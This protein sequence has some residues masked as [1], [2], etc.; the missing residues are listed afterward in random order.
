MLKV[1]AQYILL[2]GGSLPRVLRNYLQHYFTM[3]SQETNITDEGSI[4]FNISSTINGPALAVALG[5]EMILGIITNL[6]IIIASFCYAKTLKNSSTILLLFLAVAN[7]FCCV[8][9]M[10][11]QIITAAVQEWIFGNTVE[12]REGMCVFVGYILSFS[13]II[14]YY[15]LGAISFDRFLMIVKPITHRTIMTP[16]VVL[17][18]CTTIVAIVALYAA[19]PLFGVGAIIFLPVVFTCSAGWATRNTAFFFSSLFIATIPVIIII[20]TSVWTFMF[21]RTFIKSDHQRR[22]QSIRTTNRQEYQKNIYN[23]RI[24]KLFGIFG[25]LLISN[26]ISILPFIAIGI[27]G[28]LVGFRTIPDPIYGIVMFVF[29]LN[30]IANA[31]AQCYFRPELKKTLLTFVKKIKTLYKCDKIVCKCQK[32]KKKYSPDDPSNSRSD[33]VSNEGT[34]QKTVEI[35]NI[36]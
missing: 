18:I 1:Y 8:V 24:R 27:T 4:N 14:T 7:L 25:T 16:I 31:I 5:I 30:N 13:V 3:E 20:I 29:F 11:F 9:Y 28:N 10:P 15:I 36:E 23:N 34:S 17:I 22:I 26:T 21:T 2:V 12:V 6:F 35:I 32:K 19:L 33:S